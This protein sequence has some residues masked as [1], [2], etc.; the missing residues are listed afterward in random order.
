MLKTVLFVL[1]ALMIPLV[2]LW[3]V[4]H[5]RRNKNG[6]KE[7]VCWVLFAVQTLVSVG[8]IISYV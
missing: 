7:I 1:Y 6:S 5:Y 2:P 3:G 4:R 8:S